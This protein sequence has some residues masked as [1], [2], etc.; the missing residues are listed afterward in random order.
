MKRLTTA[1]IVIFLFTLFGCSS[2]KIVRPNTP[3]NAAHLMKLRID[4]QDYSDFQSLFGEGYEH[5]VSMED[6][7]RFGE[8]T[9]AGAGYQTYEL[10]TFEN[11]E[12][13]LVAFLPSSGEEGQYKIVNVQIVPEEMNPFFKKG[14]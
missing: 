13:L 9:T 14:F 5:V 8:I 3:M 10:L 6:F 2:E 7:Q 12:M 4:F 1:Y 11:G